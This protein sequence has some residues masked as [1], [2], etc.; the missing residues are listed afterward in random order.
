MSINIHIRGINIPQTTSAESSYVLAQYD[1]TGYV[2]FKENPDD[3]CKSLLRLIRLLDK[4]GYTYQS[5]LLRTLRYD[6]ISGKRKD[7]P[8]IEAY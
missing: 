8:D 2:S 7:A 6:L 3:Y 5:G 4:R 1:T